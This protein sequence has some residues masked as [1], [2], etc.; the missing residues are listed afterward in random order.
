MEDLSVITADSFQGQEAD[1]VIL[2]LVRSN[3]DGNIGFL[4]DYRRMNVAMT[5]A[6]LKL[7]VIGDSTK[8]GKD[9]FYKAFIDYTEGCGC[10]HSVFELIY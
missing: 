7:I 9:G 10:Y 3:P 8:L 1:V 5:R 6:K 2:S 4:K